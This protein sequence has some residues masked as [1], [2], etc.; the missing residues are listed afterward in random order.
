M[1]K[2]LHIP[3]KQYLAK[4][5]NYGR[6][7]VAEA[8]NE[9]NTLRAIGK[10]FFPPQPP[11]RNRRSAEKEPHNR[12]PRLTGAVEALAYGTGFILGEPIEKTACKVLS[13]L[14]FCDP[15]RTWNVNWIES[16]GR[17]LTQHKTLRVCRTE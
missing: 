8:Q 4:Q 6:K 12:A 14:K 9:L 5:F 2:E 17:N 7:D 3:V 13:I 10:S 11:R 15:Q 1:Y 16:L